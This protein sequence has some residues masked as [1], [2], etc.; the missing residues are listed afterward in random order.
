MCAPQ[1]AVMLGCWAATNDLASTGA[2]SEAAQ[3]LFQ[4]MRTTV[5]LK[6]S[7]KTAL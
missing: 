4:C 7:S 3:T 1:L 2:C 6:Y 5:R